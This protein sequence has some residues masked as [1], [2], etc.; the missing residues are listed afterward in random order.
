MREMI[1]VVRSLMF[2][3][4]PN[5]ICKVSTHDGCCNFFYRNLLS[6]AFIHQLSYSSMVG[7]I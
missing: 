5:S 2:S 1:P 6:L 7:P 3:K 4:F